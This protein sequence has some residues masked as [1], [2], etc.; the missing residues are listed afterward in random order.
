[1][2]TKIMT[3]FNLF[4][5]NVNLRKL[6][7]RKGFLGVAVIGMLLTGCSKPTSTD[8]SKSIVIT[9]MPDL[10]DPLAMPTGII[11]IKETGEKVDLAQ[12]KEQYGD[13]YSMVEPLTKTQI[14]KKFAEILYIWFN[15]GK[16]GTKRHVAGLNGIDY[17]GHT[18]FLPNADDL[19]KNT[20]V[21]EQ[22]QKAFS[23]I[24]LST[25]PK[26][27]KFG[28]YY[29]EMDG[30]YGFWDTMGIKEVFEKGE[31]T[32]LTDLDKEAVVR[33]YNIRL[34]SECKSLQAL[35]Y[36]SKVHFADVIPEQTKTK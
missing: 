13:L 22:N 26:L 21:L 32:L 4:M 30:Y 9:K 35:G 1:M 18:D 17:Y 25:D 14:N 23:T 12:L 10:G 2:M 15:Y 20:M 31:S 33:N 29:L 3:D 36:D 28:S 11:T 24:A 16:L 19:K 6:S 5:T 34:Y 27:S 8:D 7:L